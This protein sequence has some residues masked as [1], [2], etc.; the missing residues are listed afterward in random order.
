[1]HETQEKLKNSARVLQMVEV[2]GYQ[3]D[4]F[5]LNPLYEFQEQGEENGRVLGTLA[6]KGELIHEQKLKA[7]GLSQISV[8]DEGAFG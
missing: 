6:K 2:V 7:A 5:V 4:H 3:D 1:M 8:D